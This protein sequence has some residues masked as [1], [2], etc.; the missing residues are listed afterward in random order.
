[1]AQ[2]AGL[3]FGTA[4]APVSSKMPTTEGGIERVADLGLGC[5]EV[6]FV[7]GVKMSQS[8]AQMVSEVEK[9]KGV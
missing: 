7:R 9:K 4:G 3:I 6:Q 5:M 8:M 1:M 2:K